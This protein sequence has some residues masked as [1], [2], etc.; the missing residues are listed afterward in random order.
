MDQKAI[1]GNV[2]TAVATATVLGFLGWAVGVFGAGQDALT[3]KQIKA[4]IAEVMILDSGDTY[5]A[6]LNSI[7]KSVGEI[8]VAIN[9]IKEDIDDLEAAVSAL[10]AQ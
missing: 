6:T 9:A 4:V 8:N 10:A 3:E 5:A 7:D 2:I 1:G